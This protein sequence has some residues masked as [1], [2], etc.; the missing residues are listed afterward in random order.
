M[1]EDIIMMKILL[2]A[3][4]VTVMYLRYKLSEDSF[5]KVIIDINLI[6]LMMY[7]VWCKQ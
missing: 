3:L 7:Y 5:A 4:I 2:S 6:F 1:R